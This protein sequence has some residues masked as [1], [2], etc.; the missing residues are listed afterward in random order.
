MDDVTRRMV[1]GALSSRTS[2]VRSMRR[3]APNQSLVAP[4][5]LALQASLPIEREWEYQY[6]IVMAL[7]IH[8][9]QGESTT[10]LRGLTD[11]V[12]KMVVQGVG[13]ALVRQATDRDAVMTEILNCHS[14]EMIQGAFRALAVE[15]VVLGEDA[16]SAVML[17]LK[18]YPSHV[19]YYAVV[20]A[21]GWRRA[22]VQEWLRTIAAD[23]RFSKLRECVVA[24]LDGRYSQV[25]IL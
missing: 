6:N 16:T 25:A 10:L 13:H 23:S 14:P 3:L 17:Y 18:G 19:M 20:A 1:T 9:S 2:A 11:K 15:R 5:C 4:L 12:P 21:A 24:S 7:S 22:D 8:D